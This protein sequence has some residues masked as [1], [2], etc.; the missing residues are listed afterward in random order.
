MVKFTYSVPHENAT[1]QEELITAKYS[2]VVECFP[3]DEIVFNWTGS[4]WIIS[5]KD[6]ILHEINVSDNEYRQLI[7][8]G[9]N[10]FWELEYDEPIQYMQFI[11]PSSSIEVG[12]VILANSP[13]F[14]VNRQELQYDLVVVNDGLVFIK[15]IVPT[16]NQVIQYKVHFLNSHMRVLQMDDPKQ[17]YLHYRKISDQ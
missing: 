17:K 12:K 16:S 15:F 8:D 11:K 5:A 6:A 3:G 4:R 7:Q 9:L 2:K 10:G 13:D 1:I 14:V